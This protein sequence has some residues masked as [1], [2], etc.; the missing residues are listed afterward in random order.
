[1]KKT[2]RQWFESWEDFGQMA[3]EEAEKQDMNALHSNA[4]SLAQA[5][6]GGFRWVESSQGHEFWE[7]L[8]D[9]V[10]TPED[11]EYRKQLQTD[12]D[13]ILFKF[14]MSLSE[15]YVKEEIKKNLPMD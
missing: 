2:I 15:E 5:I 13:E 9:A 1:M 7:I 6:S 14:F 11:E 10:S 4:G 8:R 3:I 12:V